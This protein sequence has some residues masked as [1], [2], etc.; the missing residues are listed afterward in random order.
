MYGDQTETKGGLRVLYVYTAED[1]AV[2]TV[3][4]QIGEYM[5]PGLD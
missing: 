3:A 5:Q 2:M 1:I 4:R